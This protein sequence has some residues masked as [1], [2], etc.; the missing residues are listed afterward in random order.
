MACACRVK[1]ARIVA[2]FDLGVSASSIPSS[3]MRGK[4]TS[5]DGSVDLKAWD[6]TELSISWENSASNNKV[7]VRVVWGESVMSLAS[8]R[9]RLNGADIDGDGVMFD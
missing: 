3:C 2:N 6:L 9:R 5:E 8:S 7:V 1:I 4:G